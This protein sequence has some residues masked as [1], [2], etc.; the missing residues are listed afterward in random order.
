MNKLVNRPSNR[1]SKEP[2]T[3]KAALADGKQTSLTFSAPD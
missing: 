1:D 2:G 3:T